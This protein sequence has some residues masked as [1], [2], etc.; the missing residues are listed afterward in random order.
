MKIEL[1]THKGLIIENFTY[2]IISIFHVIG[3]ERLT[4]NISIKA[5]NINI[6]HECEPFI[7]TNGIPSNEQLIIMVSDYVTSLGI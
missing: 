2:T 3:S 1:N 7:L 4:A 5:P 6:M